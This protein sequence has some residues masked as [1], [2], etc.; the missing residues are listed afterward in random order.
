M[1]LHSACYQGHVEVVAQLLASGSDPNAPADPA[2]T[3]WIS[4]AGRSPRP[5]NCVAIASTMTERHVEIARLLLQHGAVV[6]G[7]VL[8]DF[9]IERAS[10]D[11][12]TDEAFAR[13]LT[14]GRAIA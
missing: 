7:S 9:T 12:A 10:L 6:D 4:C 5:L 11:G 2:E 1:S 8:E 3:E 13:L 14:A